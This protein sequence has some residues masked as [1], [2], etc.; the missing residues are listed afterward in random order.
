MTDP[1]RRND[2]GEAERLKEALL[3]P[4]LAQLR[5]LVQRYGDDAALAE[6]VRRVIVD[7][8]RK[9]GVQDHDRVA[10]ALAPLVVE[11]VAQEIPRQHSRIA[12]SLLPYANRLFA[13]G[14]GGAVTGLARVV[15]A[16]ASPVVWVQRL[17]GLVRGQPTGVVRL[18]RRLWFEGMALLSETRD[19]DVFSDFPPDRILSFRA[20]AAA[21]LRSAGDGLLLSNHQGYHWMVRLNGMVWVVVAHGGRAAGI[22][23]RLAQIFGEFERHWHDTIEH[24]VDEPPGPVLA[25]NMARDLEGRCRAA[26]GTAPGDP[27]PRPR[28]WFGYAVL[29]A[30]LAALVAWGGWQA[31][32]ARQDR[33]MVA[34]AEAALKDQ[35]ALA[36]LPLS[37]RYDREGERLIVRGV[38]ADRALPE[39]VESALKSAMPGRA[40]D[41]LLIAPPPVPKPVIREVK[42]ATGSTELAKQTADLANRLNAAERQIAQLNLQAWFDQQIIRFSTNIEFYDPALVDQQIQ[43]IVGLFR[44]WPPEFNLRIVGYSDATGSA[45][46]QDKVALDRA[47]AVMKALIGAGVPPTRLMAVGRGATKPLSFIQGDN[48]INRRV[49]FEVYTPTALGG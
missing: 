24:M 40:V 6:S 43:A 12:H 25:A 22:G 21:H 33:Q 10:E 16:V 13:L 39:Q 37:I 19:I 47:L 29:A 23:D 20:A 32:M 35:P 2:P 14:A 38:V 28:P 27:L 15:E 34:E 49:E 44:D 48:S 26:F 42:P 46:A 31:W 5:D 30:G 4:E 41:V 9:A 17:R 1:M 36:R 11:T 45:G 7:V 8:L 3:G 18:G